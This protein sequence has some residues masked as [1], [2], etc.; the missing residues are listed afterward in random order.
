MQQKSIELKRCCYSHL[1]SIILSDVCYPIQYL[2]FLS[3]L[4][5]CIHFSIR[6]VAA[7]TSPC[8]CWS[9]W[10]LTKGWMPQHRL[11]YGSG[12]WWRS[13]R[14]MRGPCSSGLCGAGPGYP[15]Q[16]PTSGE[17]ILYSRCVLFVEPTL[18]IYFC[19]ILNQNTFILHWKGFEN[20]IKAKFVLMYL[21]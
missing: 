13:C 10:P 8:T 20:K 7:Q 14:T 12:R 3:I 16:S 15:G 2:S 21:C 18:I 11:W 17:E 4:T 9:L 5:P 19:S 6:C 1:Y